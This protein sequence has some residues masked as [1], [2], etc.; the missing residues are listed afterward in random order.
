MW[1]SI[2]VSPVVEPN[3]MKV[4]SLYLGKHLSSLVLVGCLY[5]AFWLVCLLGKN[6]SFPF[7]SVGGTF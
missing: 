3:S 7:T 1:F 6:H 5:Q 4:Y 2:Q